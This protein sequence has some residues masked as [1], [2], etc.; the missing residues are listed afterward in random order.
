MFDLD[1]FKD[2]NDT[3]GHTPGDEVL[4]EVARRLALLTREGDSIARLGGDEFAILLPNASEEE[5]IKVTRRASDSLFLNFVG[6]YRG[7]PGSCE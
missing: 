1:H 7:A 3:F 5:G 4:R 2:V 6:T